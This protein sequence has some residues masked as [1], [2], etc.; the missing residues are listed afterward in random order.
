MKAIRQRRYGPP[1]V[2]QLVDV[3]RPQVDDDGVLV[4]VRAASI[5]VADWHFMRGLPLPVR[6]VGGLRRPKESS[7]GYDVAGEVAAVGK[8]VTRFRVGDAVFGFQRGAWAEYVYGSE[9]SFVPKPVRLTFEQA[10]AIGGAGCTALQGLRDGGQLKPG[11][12]VL[13]NGASGA[14]GTFAV[15][16]A[17]ALGARVTAV[18]GTGNVDLARS[19]GADVVID[20]TKDDFTKGTERYNLLLDIATSRSLAASRRTLVRN[21]TLVMIGAP[22]NGRAMTPILARLLLAVVWSRLA[23]RQMHPFLAKVNNADLVVL[24]ELIDAGT[25]TPVIDRTY[26]MQE[27][28]AAVGYLEQGHARGKVVI[29]V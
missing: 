10:A 25:V 7:V 18:C 12:H 28:A 4:R 5:N 27:I 22:G 24:K 21:G 26:P 23:S 15:Q 8:N 11:Q 1:D 17:K 20:Y 2:L 9:S 14:V 3:D 19:L 13:I 6:L 29:T 16:I